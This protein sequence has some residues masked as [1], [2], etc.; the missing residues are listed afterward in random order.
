MCG[1]S[2]E[3][4]EIIQCLFQTQRVF[5][6]P[7]DSHL[8]RLDAL[9]KPKRSLQV[10]GRR[11]RAGVDGCGS[12]NGRDDLNCGAVLPPTRYLAHKTSRVLDIFSP[13]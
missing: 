12:A 4:R 5:L 2:E 8:K 1:L 9:I 13:C 7:E 6:F 3:Y 11:G 10:A